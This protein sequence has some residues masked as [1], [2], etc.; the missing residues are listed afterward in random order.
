MAEGIAN[1]NV[2]SQEHAWEFKKEPGGSV[3]LELARVRAR[4]GHDV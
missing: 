2:L 3:K 1:A 4:V